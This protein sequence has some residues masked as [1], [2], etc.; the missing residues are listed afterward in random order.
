VTDEGSFDKKSLVPIDRAF[1]SSVRAIRSSARE[2]NEHEVI[3][4]SGESIPYEH[5]VL[6]LGSLWS[7]PLALPDSRKEAIE[8]LRLFKQELK[9]AQH[10]LV[11]G[12]GAVGL[13]G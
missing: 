2:I 7:G 4:E 5:L 11:V 13:G 9:A 3:T 6:G 1:D 12:G 8:H 10:I